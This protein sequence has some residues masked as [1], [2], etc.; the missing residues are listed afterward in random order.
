MLTRWGTK[1]GT[2][3]ATRDGP[4]LPRP[5][6]ETRGTQIMCPEPQTATVSIQKTIR[7]GT[8]RSEPERHV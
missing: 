7:Q 3:E 2:A 8:T 5:A 1:L 4:E 6:A